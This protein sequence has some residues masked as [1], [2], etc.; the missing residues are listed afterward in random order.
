MYTDE[1]VAAKMFNAV[2]KGYWTGFDESL[3]G[4]NP[5]VVLGRAGAEADLEAVT[6]FLDRWVNASMARA[7]GVM[8]EN[9]DLL[10]EGTVTELFERLIRPY[11]DE[12]DYSCIPPVFVERIGKP[13]IRWQALRQI[14]RS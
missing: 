13:P 9:P 8:Q 12:H 14:V 7:W 5:K 2:S 11:G 1:K 10:K 3:E 4:L 6:R